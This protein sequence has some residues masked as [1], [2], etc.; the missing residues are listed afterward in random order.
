VLAGVLVAYGSS[1]STRRV[2]TN[3]EVAS[4][5]INL[6]GEMEFWTWATYILHSSNF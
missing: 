2:R 3:F 6:V 1:G 4:A 5:I